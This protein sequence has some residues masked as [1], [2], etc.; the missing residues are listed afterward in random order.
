MKKQEFLLAL[1]DALQRDEA[2]EEN[3]K[4]N[5][6]EEWDSLAIVSLI[7]LYDQLFAIQVTGNTLRECQS[8]SDLIALAKLQD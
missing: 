3:M 4:L 8:V 7:A 6:L 1:Q 5:E 2:L